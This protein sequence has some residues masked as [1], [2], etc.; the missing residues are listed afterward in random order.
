MGHQKAIFNT[1]YVHYKY[2]EYS[3]Y[4]GDFKDVCQDILSVHETSNALIAFGKTLS[5]KLFSESTPDDLKDF[6]EITGDKYFPQT[7]RDVFIWIHGKTIGDVFD[8][9]RSI[10]N[11][12]PKNASLKLEKDGFVYHD[13]R[14]LTGFVDGSANPQGEKA[15]DAA[16]IPSGPAKGGSI[17]LTQQWNHKLDMFAV[18]P[19]TEQEKVI[20][21]TKPD[22]IEFTDE[23][24]PENSHV[25]KTDIKGTKI[26]RRSTPFGNLQE[27]GLYFMAFSCETERFTKQLQ[28]MAG[29]QGNYDRIMDFS[30]PVSSSYF[31]CPSEELLKDI[32]QS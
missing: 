24:M 12:L 7:Q 23:N 30:T 15:L 22:S 29:S 10:D 32:A 18:M 28:S 20:G 14:D 6:E 1:D 3:V 25:A 26:Y 5:Q 13:S 27:H 8:R 2:L 21:R 17:L 11:A 9:A 16:L 19:T 4:E 31:F